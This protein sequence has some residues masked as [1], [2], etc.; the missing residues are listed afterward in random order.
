L[1][2][3]LNER[4]VSKMLGI[5]LGSLRR[6]RLRREGPPYI[7]LGAGRGGA[8]RYPLVA[9]DAWLASRPAWGGQHIAEVR[10]P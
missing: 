3:F 4:A 6:W 8:V 9:L 10:K 1:Q 5:S 2:S 7:K